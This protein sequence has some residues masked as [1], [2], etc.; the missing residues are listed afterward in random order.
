MTEVN[1]D[2]TNINQQNINSTVYNFNLE[3]KVPRHLT[4]P[5][6]IPEV[7]LGREDDLKAIRQKL[8]KENNLIL[9]VNGT[10]GIGKTAL[11]SYYYHKFENE[12]EHRAWVLGGDN[13][14]NALLSLATPLNVNFQEGSSSEERL[15]LL[16][17]VLANL[18]G[19]CLLVL[20][21]VNQIEELEHYY[22]QLRRFNNFHILFTTRVTRFAEV[23]T[24]KVEALTMNKA[25]DLFRL[26]YKNYSEV[27]HDLFRKI[28]RAVAGNTLILELLAKNINEINHDETFYNLGDLLTD[29]QEKGLLELSQE[30]KVFTIYRTQKKAKP[31]D[32]IEAMYE[33]HPLDELE[34]QLLS[35][36]AVLPAEAIE[37][38]MLKELI[39]NIE[40]RDLSNKLKSLQQKGWL[41]RSTNKLKHVQYKISPV[42]QEIIRSKNP[43][44]YDDCEVLVKSLIGSLNYK[45]F[46]GQF[47]NTDRKELKKMS[48]YGEAVLS[49][50]KGTSKDLTTLCERIGTY[51]RITGDFESAHKYFKRLRDLSELLFK[52][53]ET[54]PD[55]KSILSLSYLKL[56]ELQF[57]LGLLD[58]ALENFEHDLRVAEELVAEDTSNIK[59]KQ[60]LSISYSKLGETY[61]RLEDF[62]KAL[63]YLLR[64]LQLSQELVQASP[65][66]PEL[67]DAL[68]VSHGIVGATYAKLGRLELS[69]QSFKN[70]NR[71]QVKLNKEFPKNIQY[72]FNLGFS[73]SFLGYG[74]LK[75]GKLDMGLNAFIEFEA[76]FA[77]LFEANSTNIF[78]RANFAEAQAI[79]AALKIHC[80]Q[81]RDSS[82]LL[83]ASRIF[84][85]LFE[86]SQIPGYHNKAELIKEMMLPNSDLLACAVKMSTL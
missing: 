32:V 27:D 57:E 18:E 2:N 79:T 24:H 15:N 73:Y 12:Y 28:Y 36:F 20:D 53:D 86:K 6:F 67:K 46:S 80:K 70:C 37:Y 69:L 7:F 66:D 16:L 77:E 19:T 34:V 25:L 39:S 58:Q 51:H 44:L 49:S 62:D 78:I 56:G 55:L 41:A 48:L 14:G 13:I 10:G 5:P 35:S 45:G 21:N 17:G 81:L 54:N 60:I 75:Q 29:L 83:E 72:K 82:K 74:Y 43:N 68:A 1:N 76:Y 30:E 4:T 61:S 26:Y 42:I 52:T 59:F 3:R 85:E 23:N 38:N 22:R 50:M 11:A 40:S 9:L 47:D 71:I 31:K 64:D 63:E 65:N 33:I 84:E 8:L